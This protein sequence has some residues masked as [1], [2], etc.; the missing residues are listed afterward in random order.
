MLSPMAPRIDLSVAIDP[1]QDHCFNLG[2]DVTL[3]HVD[4]VVAGSASV[5]PGAATPLLPSQEAA[6]QIGPANS[7]DVEVLVFDSCGNRATRIVQFQSAGTQRV[8]VYLPLGLCPPPNAGDN[9]NRTFYVLVDPMNRIPEVNPGAANW[10]S[11][12]VSCVG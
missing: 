5:S 12:S 9:F 7:T 1:G 10:D 6:I 2:F 4:P 11:R 3:R 8:Q